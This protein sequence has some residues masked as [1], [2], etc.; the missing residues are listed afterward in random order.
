M[1]GSLLL[2]LVCP[3]EPLFCTDADEHTDV[4]VPMPE[5]PFEDVP[6]AQD[7]FELEELDEDDDDEVIDEGDESELFV[8]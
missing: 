5:E 3:L 6:D 1:N 7:R 8:V 2:A 4:A